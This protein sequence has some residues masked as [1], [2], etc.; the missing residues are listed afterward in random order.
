M[1]VTWAT[2]L[3]GQRLY[4]GMIG[5]RAGG[6]GSD[7][8]HASTYRAQVTVR[9]IAYGRSACD[10]GG[11]DLARQSASQWLSSVYL[12]LTPLWCDSTVYV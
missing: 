8:M 2:M 9:L 7:G 4:T 1:S 5:C 11:L 6:A 3:F 12:V 10:G